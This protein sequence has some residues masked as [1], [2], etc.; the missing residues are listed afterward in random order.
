MKLFDALQLKDKEMIC[1]VGAGGK[2]SLMLELARECAGK[3]ARVLVTTSTKMF[4]WQLKS[5]SSKIILQSD[6]KEL[7]T[8]LKKSLSSIN[9]I[10]AGGELTV[11]KKVTGLSQECLNLIYRSDLFDYVLVEADG[12]RGKPLKAPAGNEPVLPSLAT[13]VLPVVGIDILGCPLTEEYVHRH[14][15]VA[16]IT[17]PGAGTTV[18][19][20]T[21][22]AIVRRYAYLT[23]KISAGIQL[24]PVL[25]KADHEEMKIT[26]GK[27]ARHL[28]SPAIKKVLITSAHLPNPVWE[29]IA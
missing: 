4:D 21:V 6:P 24:V 3:G 8:A 16:E 9:L 26:A 11:D 12:A 10:A 13:T 18:T 27:L 7:L 25:N 19:E 17:G 22:L 15:L 29:V 14:H 23:G 2:S 1:F 28:L 20:A 5:C